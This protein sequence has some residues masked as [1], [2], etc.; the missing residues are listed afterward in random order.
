LVPF[1]KRKS[2]KNPKIYSERLLRKKKLAKERLP[3][4]REPLRL[5]P[6][7]RLKEAKPRRK[8]PFKTFL[9]LS[10]GIAVFYLLFFSPYFQV[11]TV[12]IEG[13]E[14]L[15]QTEIMNRLPLSKNIFLTNLSLVEQKLLK[16]FPEISEVAIYK[17][18]PSVLK[19]LILK[20]EP[21]IAWQTGADIYLVDAEGVCYKKISPADLSGLVLVRDLLDLPVTPGQKV[22][23]PDFVD[24]LTTASKLLFEGGQ[25]RISQAFLRGNTFDLDL[26]LD[27]NIHLFLD[28]VR[29]A[30]P[31]VNAFLKIITEKGGLVHDYV[32]VRISGLAYLK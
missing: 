19:V 5:R 18:L 16:D 20:R 10:L 21:K 15:D 24:F 31:Q 7:E 9:G 29:E 8:L 27:R 28:P 11:K 30:E 26:L 4:Q 1:G 17:G 3:I 14:G 6:A 2:L 32:D 22:V 25:I 23:P 13:G 12:R